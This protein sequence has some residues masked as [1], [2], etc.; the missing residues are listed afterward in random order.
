M[1]GMTSNGCSTTLLEEIFAF[2]TEPEQGCELKTSRA[3]AGGDNTCLGIRTWI[4][5]EE[6]YAPN[7]GTLSQAGWSFST[8]SEVFHFTLRD[9]RDN[10]SARP[11]S[12]PLVGLAAEG[13]M[14]ETFIVEGGEGLK[15]A[16]RVDLELEGPRVSDLINSA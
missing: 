12:S 8:E 6:E 3:L 1:M 14:G 2:A 11:R 4:E 9:F 5:G 15:A 13:P 16:E 7:F 10:A